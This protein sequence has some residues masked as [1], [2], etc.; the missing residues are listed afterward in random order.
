MHVTI[1]QDYPIMTSKVFGRE[2]KILL[3]ISPR[4]IGERDAE[5]QIND[6]EHYNCLIEIFEEC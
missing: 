6:Y 3:V 2:R 5:T 4:N 1:I